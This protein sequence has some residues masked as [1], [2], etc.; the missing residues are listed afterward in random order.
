MGSLTH[1]GRMA[2]GKYL[3]LDRF[4]FTESYS[5]ELWCTGIAGRIRI[6]LA[7][8]RNHRWMY[9]GRSL[10]SLV[11]RCGFEKVVIL[12]PGDTTIQAPEGLNLAEREQE[13]VYVEGT[14]PNQVA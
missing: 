6:A 12:K 3:K 14:R 7:G 11:T 10:A 8:L 13:S 4:S 2:S 5:Y 1:D 9:D